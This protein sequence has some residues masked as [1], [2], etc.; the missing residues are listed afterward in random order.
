MQM[1]RA[2]LIGWIGLAAGLA[3]FVG[4]FWDG[5]TPIALGGFWVFGTPQIHTRRGGC[6]K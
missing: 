4:V 6:W 3:F 2:D 1:T 5:V